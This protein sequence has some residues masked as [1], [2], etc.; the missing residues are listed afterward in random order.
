MQNKPV[1]YETNSSEINTTRS[2]KDLD[3]IAE[4]LLTDIA[5]AGNISSSRLFTTLPLTQAWELQR[6]AAREW[7]K[8]HKI[9]HQK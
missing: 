1:P 8:A 7:E 3:E 5:I 4:N 9:S 6:E 2:V